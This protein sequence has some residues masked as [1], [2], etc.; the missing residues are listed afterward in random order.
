MKE[1]PEVPLKLQKF[2]YIPVFLS[3]IEPTDI[4]QALTDNSWVEAMHE[5]FAQ[6]RNMQVWELVDKQGGK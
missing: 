1:C 6:F 2:A 5:E 3:Q 4:V